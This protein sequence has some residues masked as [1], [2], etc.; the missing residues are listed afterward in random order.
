SE[1]GTD[2]RIVLEVPEEQL[3]AFKIELRER[4]AAR[5]LLEE[6]ES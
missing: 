5:A 3:E 2:V 4:T 1:Y 6:P